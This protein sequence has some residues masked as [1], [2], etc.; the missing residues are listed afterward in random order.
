M[1][2]QIIEVCDYCGGRSCEKEVE[3]SEFKSGPIYSNFLFINVSSEIH[4][5]ICS[6][7]VIKAL[8]TLLGEPKKVE[9]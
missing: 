1:I 4:R 2:Q 6:S 7:C 5:T 3:E 8:D 9:P